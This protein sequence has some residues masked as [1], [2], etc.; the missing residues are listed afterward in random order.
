M[1]RKIDS[2]CERLYRQLDWLASFGDRRDD[3]RREKA[4]RKEP[5]H[6]ATV[7]SFPSCEFADRP[8]FG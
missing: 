7:D 5:A 1:D 6:R 2:P 8:R 3:S 4:E